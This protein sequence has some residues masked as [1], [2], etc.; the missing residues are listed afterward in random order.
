MKYHNK[1]VAYHL[2]KCQSVE[3]SEY[4][5]IK[6]TGDK[7][8]LRQYCCFDSQYEASIW[9]K[10]CEHFSQ[11][12]VLRQY[13]ALICDSSPLTPKGKSWAIDFAIRAKND[14]HK[15]AY[16]VEAKG[17]CTRDFRLTLSLLYTCS[18][19]TFQR[20]KVVFPVGKIPK[21]GEIGELRRNTNLQMI[22]DTTEFWKYLQQLQ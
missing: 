8:L 11:R 3:I 4:R 13:P 16:F 5:R 12:R 22:F 17:Y 10:L 2:A 6:N 19:K 1:I 7:D 14:N 18:P 21:T 15:I 20:L 9:L